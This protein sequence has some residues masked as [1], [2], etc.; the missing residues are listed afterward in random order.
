[1]SRFERVIDLQPGGLACRV[2]VGSQVLERAGEELDAAGLRGRIRLVADETAWRLHGARL[3]GGLAAAQRPV[4]WMTLPSGE[5]FKTLQTLSRVYDWL[6]EVGVERGDCLM[7]MGGGVCGDLAGFAAATILRG[8]ALV[9]VPTTLLAQVDSSIGGK[10]G[11]NHPRGK[12]LIGAFHQPRLVLADLSTLATLPRRELAAGWAEVVK[13][14]MTL[15]GPFFEEL[16]HDAAALLELDLER[17]GQAIARAIE[18]K[19]EVVAEDE[20]EASR[21][22]VLNYGHTIGHALEAATGYQRYLHGEAVAIGMAGEA[23]IAE[24]LGLLRADDRARQAAL[25]SRL[26]LPQRCPAVAA[27]ALWQP[28]SQDKKV[29]DQR[30]TWVLPT[31]IG[32]VTLRRDVADELV[33]EVLHAMT[34]D[35]AS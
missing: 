4:D 28:M 25:L 8:I 12:N 11:I 9:Q 19:G 23:L 35:A 6:L 7:A 29:R 10:T 1:M 15:D 17:A 5:E 16:E 26:G 33:A 31:G 32:Q 21:R 13:M 24:K 22:M 27:A 14:A 20:R 3:R 30:L 18:L 34:A 2:V